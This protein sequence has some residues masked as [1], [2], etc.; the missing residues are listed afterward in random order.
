MDLET[1]CVVDAVTDKA[2]VRYRCRDKED[3][4][5]P[6]GWEAQY[7][8]RIFLRSFSNDGVDFK[9]FTES[10]GLRVK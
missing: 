8:G 9:P 4:I 7:L 1:P 3:R 10:S 6:F 2:G 5:E